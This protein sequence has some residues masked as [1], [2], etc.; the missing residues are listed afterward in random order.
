[1][2]DIASIQRYDFPWPNDDKG[3]NIF[4][5]NLENDPLVAFHGTSESN[6]HSIIQ[7][8]FKFGECLP[9]IS[10]AKTSAL[11][12]GY[13]CGKRS[14]TSPDGVVIAVKFESLGQPGVAEE[15][16]CIHLY[17]QGKQ[18]EIV[19]YCIVPKSYAHT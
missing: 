2:P 7:H 14:E 9:S 12:L 13:A 6:L 1:M 8:G 17:P 4:P 15:V 5:T 11:P 3:Y 18:P 10:F 16:S 19:G